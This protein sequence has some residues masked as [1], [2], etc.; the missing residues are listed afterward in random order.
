MICL[1]SAG[2]LKLPRI[3]DKM[4]TENTSPNPYESLIFKHLEYQVAKEDGTITSKL[5]SRIGAKIIK[6]IYYL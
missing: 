1:T 4:A 5:R 3:T 2:K 6:S